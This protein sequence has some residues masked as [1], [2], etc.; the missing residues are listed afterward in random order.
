[1]R[2]GLEEIIKL[3]TDTSYSHA[4]RMISIG[5]E[6]QALLD[7]LDKPGV[8]GGAKEG[9]SLP[10]KAPTPAGAPSK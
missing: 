10:A 1:M 9:N 8:V 4:A 3:T 7:A 2:K 6:A 5:K